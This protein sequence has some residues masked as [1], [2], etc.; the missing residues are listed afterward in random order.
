MPVAKPN[1]A[2]PGTD[3][4]FHQSRKYMEKVT[5]KGREILGFVASCRHSKCTWRSVYMTEAGRDMGMANHRRAKVKEARIDHFARRTTDPD[6]I[7]DLMIEFCDRNSDDLD[8]W[9][10]AVQTIW[11]HFTDR[12]IDRM[13]AYNAEVQ[14]H[15]GLTANA[16]AQ[17]LIAQG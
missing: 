1:T 4:T 15:M 10:R 2:M 7:Q 14:Y 17:K 8:A 12:G 3:P 16:A 13:P 5:Y 9:V 6:K 11:V